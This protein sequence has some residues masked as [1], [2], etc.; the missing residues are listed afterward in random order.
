MSSSKSLID[1]AALNRNPREEGH[2]FVTC[3]LHRPLKFILV[4]SGVWHGYGPLYSVWSFFVFCTYIG[5]FV[6]EAYWWVVGLA[7]VTW[8][9]LW[10]LRVAELVFFA[11]M[12]VSWWAVR[13]IIKERSTVMDGILADQE[14]A[15]K[16]KNKLLFIHVLLGCFLVHTA[17]TYGVILNSF[18]WDWVHYPAHVVSLVLAFFMLFPFCA[19]TT[20][21]I[22]TCLHVG[23]K[24]DEFTLSPVVGDEPTKERFTR[25]APSGQFTALNVEEFEDIRTFSA[26]FDFVCEKLRVMGD[27]WNSWLAVG[28]ISA[29]LKFL[30]VTLWDVSALQ[31]SNWLMNLSLAMRIVV[32]VGMIDLVAAGVI[33]RARRIHS[34]VI[35]WR[36]PSST[37]AA[38]DVSRCQYEHQMLIH[39]SQL[40][41]D[42]H[43][44]SM[45][46]F[47]YQ[48]TYANVF[49]VAQVLLLVLMHNS[50][51]RSKGM[52][53]RDKEAYETRQTLTGHGMNGSE[54]MHLTEKDVG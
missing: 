5:I 30:A 11:Q 48:L 12:T 46:V 8:A 50:A 42:E 20:L 22:I 54:V 33:D 6:A 17:Y 23:D 29:G 52:S 16:H 10:F 43:Y 35:N 26:R 18:K 9:S 49:R 53:P 37:D 21:F 15:E 31:Q 3:P 47:G 38:D 27:F 36:V 19:T 39:K 44:K 51:M 32:I 28:N 7:G 34:C 1:Y 2:Q 24:I 25:V 13:G 40:L 14:L 45:A 4:I 41:R